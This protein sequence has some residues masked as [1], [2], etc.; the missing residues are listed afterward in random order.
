ME[1]MKRPLI[2]TVS[3]KTIETDG[4][5]RVEVFENDSEEDRQA[6]AALFPANIMVSS[7]YNAF[8][9]LPKSL[10]EQFRRL[11]NVYFVVIGVI[12][13]IGQYSGLYQSAIDPAGILAPMMIVV[14]I[15]VIKDGV[16]DIKRH[17][18]D[19]EINNRSA[20]RLALD[21]STHSV[22]WRDILVGDCLVVFADE[23]I[24]ADCV[25]LRC[26]GIQGQCSYVETAAIDG[27][28]N[29]KLKSPVCA[30]GPHVE[31]GAVE[32]SQDK[33]QFSGNLDLLK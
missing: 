11:A 25:V 24:P 7:R 16:E 31:V 32:A 6:R 10:L 33:S 22:L 29:L 2:S 5:R 17:H 12:A 14:F 9:F 3:T 26:G 8:N 20:R 27:E 15:S 19:N 1:D 13:L 4:Q 28:T 30:I 23:E 21:G 18:A